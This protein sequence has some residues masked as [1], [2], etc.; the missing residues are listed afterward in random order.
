MNKPLADTLMQNRRQHL[1]GFSP[2]EEMDLCGHA[3]LDA[4][5]RDVFVNTALGIVSFSTNSGMPRLSFSGLKGWAGIRLS[6][7][8]YLYAAALCTAKMMAG[9]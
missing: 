9:G 7:R 1:R 2:I 8:S 3:T 4:A 6:H 5:H